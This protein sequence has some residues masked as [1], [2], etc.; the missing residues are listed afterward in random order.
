[1]W[2]ESLAA[3]EV[4]SPTH[5]P[6]LLVVLFPVFKLSCQ[7][8]AIKAPPKNGLFHTHTHCTGLL[9]LRPLDELNYFKGGRIVVAHG[10]L[11][12]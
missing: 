5:G 11:V 9:S 2:A 12:R 7:L 10:S 4:W 1:M 8:N 6:L 3:A